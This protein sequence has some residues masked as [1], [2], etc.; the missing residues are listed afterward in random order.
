MSADKTLGQIAY[1]GFD[2]L[3]DN[4]DKSAFKQDWENAAQAVAEEAIRRYEKKKW[5]E[6]LNKEYEESEDGTITEPNRISKHPASVTGND[7]PS[8]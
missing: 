6:I 2:C 4:W 7:P 5:L 1:E 8:F 3:R